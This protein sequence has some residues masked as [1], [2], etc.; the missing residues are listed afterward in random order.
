MFLRQVKETYQVLSS[1]VWALEVAAA[2]GK[3]AQENLDQT[4]VPGD[5]H[6][7]EAVL[8]RATGLDLLSQSHPA[9][10]TLAAHGI[11]TSIPPPLEP[12]VPYQLG[13]NVCNGFGMDRL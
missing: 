11:L 9:P 12:T 10:S 2:L 13:V 1:Q 8:G 3:A 4:L 6:G 5:R 7:Q